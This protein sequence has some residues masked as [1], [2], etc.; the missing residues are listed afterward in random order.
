[1]ARI[2]ALDVEVFDHP[3][4]A[5]IEAAIEF[6]LSTLGDI[7]ANAETATDL[8]DRYRTFFDCAASSLHVSAGQI[9]SALEK[10]AMID[11]GT[12]RPRVRLRNGTDVILQLPRGT[13]KI[14]LRNLAGQL[15][16][17]TADLILMLTRY[18][19]RP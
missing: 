12:A 1:M 18:A 13:A 11:P 2:P 19:V 14:S 9:R 16:L 8:N 17:D 6:A 4:Q 15:K 7:H 5:A 10:L 3:K